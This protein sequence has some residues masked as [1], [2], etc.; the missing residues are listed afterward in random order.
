[1]QYICV[2]EDSYGQQT[3]VSHNWENCN[4]RKL[5]LHETAINLEN[6]E[7]VAACSTFQTSLQLLLLILAALRFDHFDISIFNA[8]KI[9]LLEIGNFQ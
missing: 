6:K 8:K 9:V 5:D 7:K 3:G 1:M 4:I 2:I